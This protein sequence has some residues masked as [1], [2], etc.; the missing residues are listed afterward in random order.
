MQTKETA[1]SLSKRVSDLESK[2]ER[3]EADASPRLDAAAV[4]EAIRAK[5]ETSRQIRYQLTGTR[6]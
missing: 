6:S 4:A 1:A 2:V 5:I 3:L